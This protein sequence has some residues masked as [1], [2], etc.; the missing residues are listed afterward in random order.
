MELH[1]YIEEIIH[2]CP[3]KI[4]FLGNRP[5]FINRWLVK[6]E[7]ISTPCN[8]DFEPCLSTY[9]RILLKGDA[10]GLS[11]QEL[12]KNWRYYC[13]TRH[14]DYPYIEYSRNN[15]EQIFLKGEDKYIYSLSCIYCEDTADL[16][17]Y[18]DVLIPAR[19]WINGNI[20]FSITQGYMIKQHVFAVRLKKGINI[21]L[22]EKSMLARY[23]NFNPDMLRVHL[24]IIP[25][26]YLLKNK[27]HRFFD[28][29]QLKLLDSGLR[30][31][32][33]KAFY[34]CGEDIE[35]T[36]MP[37]YIREM[38]REAITVQVFNAAYQKVAECEEHTFKKIVFTLCPEM[39][40]TFL[41]KAESIKSGKKDEVYIFKG[42]FS[43]DL[44]ELALKAEGREDCDKSIP[45]S[46]RRIAS[47]PEVDTSFFKNTTEMMTD[48]F[49]EPLLEQVF[50]F[51]NA[52]IHSSPDCCKKDIF[53]ISHKRVMAFKS[54]EIDDGF[55]TYSLHFPQYYTPKKRYALIVYFVYGAG[56]ATYP[57][58]VEFINKNM[59]EGAIVLG[60]CGRGGTN[61]DYINEG[62][63]LEIIRKVI[64]VYKI[65]RNKIFCVGGCTGNIRAIG[66]IIRKP[67]I[68]TAIAGVEGTVR[69][70]IRKPEFE[71][72]KNMDNIKMYQLNNIEDA[73]FN[74]ARV[75]NTLKR[76][77]HSKS[78]NF[79]G[80]GHSQFDTMLNS[81]QLIKMLLGTNRERYPKEIFFITEEPIYNKSYWARLDYIKSLGEKARIE[82]KISGAKLIQISCRNI[83]RLALLLA[84][85]EM[86]LERSIN[87]SINGYSCNV[88]LAEYSE[89]SITIGSAG[90]FIEVRELTKEHFN[91]EYD[92]FQIN[93]RLLG[94]KRVYYGRCTVIKPCSQERKSLS[95]RIF[96]LLKDPMREKVRNY[97]YGILTEDELRPESLKG[98]SLVYTIAPDTDGTSIGDTDGTSGKEI[99][100]ELLKES[101][102]SVYGCCM[103]YRGKK[104]CGDYFALI[105][106]DSPF[107][108]E[109]SVLLAICSSGVAMAKMTEL[110]N[111]FDSSPV[112]YND[113]II[114]SE[115]AY[116][117]FRH[118]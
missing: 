39:K 2:R 17:I 55:T 79:S 13:C 80:F 14:D 25:M 24:E 16:L 62:D 78:W 43:S 65:D 29:N 50:L 6:S 87:I 81:G 109:K 76:I 72:L 85:E 108:P 37:R 40:G 77:R 117:Y 84:R 113:A 1:G 54:S 101:G 47:I 27:V 91:K 68:F 83:K 23:K 5:G 98:T 60:V 64:E 105:R 12:E 26:Q 86:G 56:Y 90:A 15:P 111:S 59:F 70:D 104:Y 61:R 10:E 95:R 57:Y 97:K 41:I 75:I 20:V 53:N 115:G 118:G 21:V 46:I 45:L 9:G 82:A 58:M 49:F 94:I 11:Q 18:A 67:D 116:E 110:I 66:M 38:D 89:S 112:F 36:V 52:V 103:E 42:D 33:D 31:T 7:P 48:Y 28:A 4:T 73:I 8:G 99:R 88:C 107:D 69:L 32:P 22:I 71:C 63:I 44:E 102:V 96:L 3:Y 100:E 93:E 74:T 34:K 35:I 92:C 106:Y 19:I 51:E 30:I 114:Y